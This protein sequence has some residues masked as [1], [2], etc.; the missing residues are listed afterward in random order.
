MT[1][2]RI[3]TLARHSRLAE[4]AEAGK[5]AKE[6]SA[7]ESISLATVYQWAR[8]A[9]IQL[10]RS[11]EDQKVLKARILELAVA[12]KSTDEIALELRVRPYAV[13]RLARVA[14]ISLKRSFKTKTDPEREARRSKMAEMYRQGVTL[15]KIGE[16]FGMTR[17]RVRQIIGPLGLNGM[18]GGASVVAKV[19]RVSRD[20]DLEAK[21]LAKYGLPVAVVR[22]LRKDGVTR[23]FQAQRQSAFNRGIAWELNLP[24][25]LPSGR[26]AANCTSVV[27]AGVSTLCPG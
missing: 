15:A 8:G 27:E 12:G 18:N 16:Q 1:G 5:T 19:R 26:R 6:I 11:G 7:A 25:G 3:S 14:G 9:G 24:S 23:A 22:Q 10:E 4:L 2:R 17:E 21:C 13:Y 20:N